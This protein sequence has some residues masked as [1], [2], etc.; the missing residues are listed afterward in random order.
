MKEIVR[1]LNQW[2]YEYYVLDNPTVS[3][4][5]YD[6][7]YDKLVLME[8]ETGI[9]LPDSPT[10]R[11]G[12]EPLAKFV[13]HTHIKRL[14]SLDKAQTFGELGDWVTKVKKLYPDAEFTVELKYDGL[15]VVVTYD[16]GEFI[17]ASTRGNG[18]TGEDIT[19]QVKTIKNVPLTINYNGL[20]E[21]GGEGIMKL[22]ALK[23]YN[24]RHPNDTLKSARNAAAGALRNLDSKV[25][26]SR[27]LGVVFYSNGYCENE[28]NSQTDLVEFLKI[29][30]FKTNDVFIKVKTFE[31]I[32]EIV[33]KIDKERSEYDFLIDGAVIK[34]DDYAIREQLGYTDKFPRWAIA[35]KFEAEQV[36]T[37]LLSVDWQV[38]RTGKLTP[39]ANLSP[40]ELCGA[41]IKRATLNN[42]GDIER[43]NL[44]TGSMVFIRR[45]NEVIPEVL[46]LAAK[47]IDSETILKPEYC[48]ACGTALVERGANLYCPNDDGCRPQI[49]QRLTHY[50]E[51]SGCD[52]EGLSDK[53][54]EQL[55]DVLNVK[56]IAALYN[57]TQSDLEKLDGFK[58]KKINNL[59]QAI[60]KSKKVKLANFIYALGI[61]NVGSV[62]AKDLARIYLNIDALSQATETELTKINEIGEVV[63][64]CIAEYFSDEFNLKQ[65]ELLSEYGI[66]PKFEK[67]A[68][69]VFSGK[70]V[71]LTGSLTKYSRSEAQKLIE[72]KGGEI[73]STVS[74]SVNL[75]I[76]GIDA[77]S[78]LDAAKAS[79]IEIIDEEQFI[80]MLEND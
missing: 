76:A 44:S 77:G 29:N 50:A 51:K 62:T 21:L 68:E 30:K 23:E 33:Q 52:I 63:A 16:K 55:V 73:S 41:T 72:Q 66:N 28:F 53:T 57:I 14:Y 22:S 25:T 6:A 27:K 42:F 38:G 35:F 1:K 61:D 58:D 46:G 3:D 11:V 12:G 36:T 39:L 59:L 56:S 34:V 80:K 17:S 75:V 5:E 32:K 7:L 45:S 15:T 31:Q 64:R 65:I 69:G 40:V 48:P 49:V 20:I 26:A 8:K 54:V 71:V 10:R 67:K 74:K 78:K 70:K 19:E 13:E 2:A 24:E 18:V 79:G 60:E 43:K 37:K 9:V 4:S 47:T